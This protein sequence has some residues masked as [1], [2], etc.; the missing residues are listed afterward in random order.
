MHR[1]IHIISLCLATAVLGRGGSSLQDTWP[2]PV[3]QCS[4]RHPRSHSAFFHN[5]HCLIAICIKMSTTRKANEFE[6]RCA[7]KPQTKAQCK[8]RRL[9]HKQMCSAAVA[10]VLVRSSCLDAPNTCVPRA[11][12]G[13]SLQCCRSSSNFVPNVGLCCQNVS[14]VQEWYVSHVARLSVSCKLPFS[15]KP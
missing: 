6:C 12:Q 1:S 14:A 4:F 2:C 3:F 15:S 8:Q 7:R 5:T 13:Y 11:K 10:C 9:A